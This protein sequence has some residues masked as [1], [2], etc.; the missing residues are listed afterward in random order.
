M[1]FWTDLWR[2]RGDNCL[3]DFDEETGARCCAIYLVEL[4]RHDVFVSGPQE[5]EVPPERME[6]IKE[7]IWQRIVKQRDEQLLATRLRNQELRGQVS[8]LERV[9]GATWEQWREA[10]G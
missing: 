9:S 2:Y 3:L 7:R 8:D 10:A 4:G 5:A 1:T 6:A